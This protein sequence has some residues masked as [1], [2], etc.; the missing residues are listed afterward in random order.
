L[1][2]QFLFTPLFLQACFTR[3]ARF[4]LFALL[5]GLDA[6]QFGIASAS[7]ISTG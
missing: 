1:F 2:L 5:G 4:I 7:I 3:L 6:I